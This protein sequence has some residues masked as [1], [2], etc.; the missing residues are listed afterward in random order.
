MLTLDQIRNRL[1]MMNIA[2][3]ANS[4]SISRQTLMKVK[5]GNENVSYKVVE[6]ISNY[7]EGLENEGRSNNSTGLSSE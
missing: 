5:N 2:K 3:M 4:L 1:K 7:F 6:E